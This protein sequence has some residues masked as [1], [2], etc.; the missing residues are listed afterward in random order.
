MFDGVTTVVMMQR[1]GCERNPIARPFRGNTAAVVAAGAAF[2]I[3][4]DFLVPKTV[5][6]KWPP[7]AGLL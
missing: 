7:V 4:A 1:G 5:G 3:G 6:K 2:T